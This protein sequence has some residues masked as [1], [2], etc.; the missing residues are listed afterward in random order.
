MRKGQVIDT[1]PIL[2]DIVSRKLGV[3]RRVDHSETVKP[4][5]AP[6]PG[7]RS[8]IYRLAYDLT[9]TTNATLIEL[10]DHPAEN[11]TLVPIPQMD[12]SG[13]VWNKTI[14]WVGCCSNRGNGLKILRVRNLTVRNCELDLEPVE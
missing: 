11:Y 10:I 9:R 2:V 7:N 13:K 8:P 5:H 3:I 1:L 4:N 6:D 12:F 14:T